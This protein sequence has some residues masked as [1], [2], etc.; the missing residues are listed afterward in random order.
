ATPSLHDALPISVTTV[1]DQPDADGKRA[2]VADKIF[3]FL[4]PGEGWLAAAWDTEI[5]RLAP[6]AA[7]ELRDH[8]K[9]WMSKPT[10]PQL[11]QL[12]QLSQRIEELWGLALRRIR[13]PEDQAPRAIPAWGPA[14]SEGGEG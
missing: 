14:T 10:K 8:A 5:K 1:H 4:L 6:E 11:T 3:H 2:G 12:Q 13:A 7:K 9:R